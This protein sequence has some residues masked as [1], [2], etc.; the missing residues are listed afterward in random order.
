MH[1]ENMSE[2]LPSIGDLIKEVQSMKQVLSN[3]YVPAH[4]ESMMK[5]VGQIEQNSSLVEHNMKVC[6]YITFFVLSLFVLFLVGVCYVMW[7][8]NYFKFISRQNLMGRYAR[9][10]SCYACYR[11]WRKA[12]RKNFEMKK[13]SFSSPELMQESQAPLPPIIREK[14]YLSSSSS[15]SSSE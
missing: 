8:M 11:P 6:Y 4:F 10:K 12:G 1:K 2:S 5:K 9:P 7:R 15:F 13:N 3:M 14:D